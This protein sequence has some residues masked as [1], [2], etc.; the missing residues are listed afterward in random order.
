MLAKRYSGFA[1]N[2][3]SAKAIE[4]AKHCIVDYLA[5][6]YAGYSYESSRIVRDFVFDH[7]A[8]GECTVIGSGQ[9][10]SSV[11][12]CM[13]NATTGHATELDDVSKAATLHVGV[14]IIPAALSI[15]ESLQLSG[16][17]FLTGTI[18]G[19]DATVKLGKAANPK[20]LLSRGF[21]PTSLCG[22]FGTA[23]ASARLLG[24]DYQRT[25]SA[26]GI[27]GSFTS[28]NL[29]CYSD[30]SL[31]KRLQPGIAASSGVTSA[32]L[33]DKGYS[34]PKSILEGPRGFFHAY[35]TDCR[36]EELSGSGPFE[37]ENISLKSHACC[38]FIQAAVD[39]IIQICSDHIIEHRL[40]Q[41]IVVELSE[42]AYNV[43]G[44]PADIKWN[45][46]SV[47]DAQ[48]SA[49]YSIAVACIEGKASLKE[50]SLSSILRADV[51]SLMEHIR[52]KHSPDLDNIIPAPA[53]IGVILNDGTKYYKD[54]PCAKGDFN[55]PFSWQE[56]VHKFDDIV[57]ES[58]LSSNKKREVLEMVQHIDEIKNIRDFTK[59][60]CG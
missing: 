12:A 11:G 32:M 24:L 54:I 17:D 9:K 25:A 60:L 29:E 50:F 45:P 27:A 28:G 56:V 44:Q 42:T 46:Q 37:I 23:L 19:Y 58:L 14:V 2:A 13:S 15:C 53:R 1:Y 7:Y 51:R 5:C 18:V 41:E 38:G 21:H 49:P 10:C 31:T 57:P 8:R 3:L 59:L 40:I 39:G 35:S 33:A 20:S 26:L 34:G 22:V 36:P 30:G 48:F 16:R 47:A 6:T 43:V 4:K 52:V 55:N